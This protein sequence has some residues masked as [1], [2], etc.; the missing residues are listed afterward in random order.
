[1]ILLQQLACKNYID[2][3]ILHWC[4]S[5]ST[6]YVH[7]LYMIT[8]CVGCTLYAKFETLKRYTA[9]SNIVKFL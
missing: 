9:A 3:K 1:M 4:L 2:L 6:C 8:V 5:A 7:E